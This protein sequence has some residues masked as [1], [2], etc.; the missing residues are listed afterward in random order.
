MR[1]VTYTNKLLEMSG[2]LCDVVRDHW[3]FDGCLI[4]LTGVKIIQTDPFIEPGLL[5]SLFLWGK[6]GFNKTHSFAENNGF[7]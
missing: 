6:G 5:S 3:S 7:Y 2:K 1:Y 4:F